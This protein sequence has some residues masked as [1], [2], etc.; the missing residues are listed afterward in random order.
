MQKGFK[1]VIQISKRIK[2]SSNLQYTKAVY[3]YFLNKQIRR[4]YFH[5][6]VFLNFI[7]KPD[8]FEDNTAFP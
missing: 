8:N 2:Y 6:L 7:L 1:T 5:F 3:N 4:F